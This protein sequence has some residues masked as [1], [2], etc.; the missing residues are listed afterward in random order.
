MELEV[1]IILSLDDDVTIVGDAQFDAGIK[2][3]DG[4]LGG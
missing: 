4:S 3:K 2:D 1:L